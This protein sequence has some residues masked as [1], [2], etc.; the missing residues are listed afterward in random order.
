MEQKCTANQYDFL[1]SI[2]ISTS[3]SG[4]YYNG[5]W[6]GSGEVIKSINP[7]T[8]EVIATI[9]CASKQEYESVL[10]AM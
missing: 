5:K 9:S 3:N 6:C 1:Q 2:G 7:S 8:E 10:A 4:C